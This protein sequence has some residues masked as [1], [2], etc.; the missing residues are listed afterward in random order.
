[1]SVAVDTN[2]LL[3]LLAGIPETEQRVAG[4]LQNL[5][6][7]G[8]VVI[9][10]VVYA[11]LLAR[12]GRTIDEVDDLLAL[13]RI[14]ASWDF[15]KA[16]WIHAGQAFAAYATRRR[17]SGGRSP[18]RLLADFLIGAHALLVGDLITFDVEFFQTNFPSL[19]VVSP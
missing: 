8:A 13:M 18:R 16:V 6:A 7:R 2:V 4:T 1:V 9:S 17:D 14:Q 11:E 10:P 3:S 19:R 15:G 5:S 12:R